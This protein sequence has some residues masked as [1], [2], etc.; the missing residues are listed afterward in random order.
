VV[1]APGSSFGDT[2]YT[3]EMEEFW[4]CGSSWKLEFDGQTVLG[5][6]RDEVWPTE[7]HTTRGVTYASARDHLYRLVGPHAIDLGEWPSDAGDSRVAGVDAWGMAILWNG[8][9]VLRWSKTG[10]WRV[11]FESHVQ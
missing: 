2:P 8:S 4:G 10:G 6:L 7:V 5:G 9:Q 11:L 3:F 1:K